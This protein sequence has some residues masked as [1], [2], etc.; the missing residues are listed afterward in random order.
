MKKLSS[1]RAAGTQKRRAWG[2]GCH[3]WGGAQTEQGN[4][5]HRPAGEGQNGGGGGKGG[6][7]GGG[8][9]PEPGSDFIPNCEGEKTPKVQRTLHNETNFKRSRKKI[10][11]GVTT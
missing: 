10:A 9:F 1:V 8:N 2:G 3:S 7:G 11:L 6:A 4:G 5:S